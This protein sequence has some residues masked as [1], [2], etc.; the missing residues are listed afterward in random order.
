VGDAERLVQVQVADVA[1]EPAGAGD[2]DQ[3]VQVGAVD[4]DLAAV[5]VHEVAD[6]GDPLLEHPVRGRVGDHEHGEVL[7]VGLD[8]VLEVVDVHVALVVAGHH[9]DAHPGHDR[10]RGVG[11]VRG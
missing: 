8:L 3:R 6:L 9:H 7:V 11:A 2:A 10:G 4:V 1:A 5:L